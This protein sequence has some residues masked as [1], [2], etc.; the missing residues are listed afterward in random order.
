MHFQRQKVIVADGEF[1]LARWN[2]SL[3]GVSSLPEFGGEVL[4]A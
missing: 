1:F 3:C 4:V 2:W